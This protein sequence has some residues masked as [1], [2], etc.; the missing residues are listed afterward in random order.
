MSLCPLCG[1]KSELFFKDEFYQCPTCAGIFKNQAFL[2]DAKDEK[3][4]YE[5]HSDDVNDLGYQKF[6]S[7]IT[8]SVLNDFTKDADGLDFG[9][10]NSQIVATV[11]QDNGYNVKVYDPFFAP[12]VEN[13]QQKYDYITSCEVIEHFN[14]PHKEFTLLK[15][16]LKED[17]KLYCMTHLYDES[18]D[19]S[20]WYYKNDPTHIFIYQAKTVAFIKNHFGFSDFAIDKRLIILSV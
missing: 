15:S 4:R 16:L 11:L 3:E 9:S 12:I 1:S 8:Q 19:F 6:V 10:G 18:I 17:G 2:L 14:N 20:K 7:P 13:L 5:L